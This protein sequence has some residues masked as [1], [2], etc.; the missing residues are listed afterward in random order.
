MKIKLP[1]I[2]PDSKLKLFLDI[3]KVTEVP[4]S[5]SYTI[6]L[7][8]IG[9]IL[10][11]YVYVNQVLWKVYPTIRTFLVG[12][13]GIG[14]D[15]TIDEAEKILRG[16]RRK[17]P[18]IGG[19]TYENMLKEL[20]QQT[21]P[22]IA[23]VPVYEL[24]S[25]MGK[26]DYQSGI[27]EG[28]TNILS[29]KDYVNASIKSDK[30]PVIL[31]KPT[32]TLHVGSTKEWLQR[33]TPD[34]AM[35]GGFF[36]RFVVVVE[37]YTGKHR[38]L[39]KHSVTPQEHR[40]SDKGREDLTAWLDELAEKFRGKGQEIYL[41]LEAV[42]LYDEWYRARHKMF[43][44]TVR[45]YAERSRDQ[46]LRFAMI[47][48]ISR[49]KDFIDAPDVQFG[50]DLMAYLA[51]R[52]DQAMLPTTIEARCAQEILKLLPASQSSL[53]GTLTQQY[54]RRKILDALE[55][56]RDSNR[57]VG[58]KNEWRQNDSK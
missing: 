37:E 27:M 57:I 2:P 26:K 3:M 21:P 47:M 32:L 42:E 14:K 40:A 41:T 33:N 16:V 4:D 55:N 18:I 6:G 25:L 56:L 15:T 48:A 22:H 9:A 53:M 19:R 7:S 8:L 20:S 35:D 52:I 31:F 29:D 5:Y 1:K 51:I 50:V 54:P 38:P 58:S 10:R 46:V 24:T 17:L 13:S 30:K 49:D 45:P 28:L 34:G 23:Y 36:P 12:P 44:P 39:I 43:P 11:R